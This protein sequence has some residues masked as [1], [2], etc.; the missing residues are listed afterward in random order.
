MPHKNKNKRNTT[1]AY[2]AELFKISK[3]NVHQKSTRVA[4]CSKLNILCETF[5][6]MNVQDLLASDVLY[7]VDSVDDN[8]KN[9]T[10]NEYFRLLRAVFALA[11]GDQLISETPML[12]IHN[13]SIAEEAPEPNPF[14]LS[15]LET[16][17]FVDSECLSTRNLVEAMAACGARI[18]EMIALKVSDVDLNNR[19]LHINSAQV[20]G[21]SKCTKTKSGN[22]VIEINDILYPILERQLDIA[23][24]YD[25]VDIKK[26]GR[27]GK[28]VTLEKEQ[29][30]FIDTIRECHYKDAKDFS[31]RYW[32]KFL[33]KANE[34]HIERTNEGIQSRGVSQLRHTFASQALTAG[35]N[36]NWLAGQMGHTDT[37]MIDK[38]YARWMTEDAS[39]QTQKIN[40]HFSKLVSNTVDPIIVPG[41]RKKVALEQLLLIKT[42][43]KHSEDH[44]LKAI[45]DSKIKNMMQELE[46]HNA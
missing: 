7:W 15:E 44:E 22:R 13:R 30:L 35:V 16:F 36:K 31:Q 10:I 37:G 25:A 4:D 20:L 28:K 45:I 24:Q 14:T 1:F 41:I 46:A 19:Q 21:V 6:E 8:Y 32:Y 40:Q 11:Q 43:L 3:K 42:T 2:F 18:S 39:D 5:G 38:V 26:K 33:T 12:K 27:N 29:Y 9:K 23:R 34:L 17:K